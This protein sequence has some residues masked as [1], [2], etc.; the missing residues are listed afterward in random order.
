VKVALEDVTGATITTATNPVTIALAANS[1]GATLS[2]TLTATPMGGVA[3]FSNL[4][5]DKASG[6]AGY[7]LTASA[8]GFTSATSNS[9]IVMPGG[10]T[11]FAVTAPVSVAGGTQFSNLSVTAFDAF[12]NVA[13]GY[14]GTVHFTSTDGQA[15]LPADSTLNQGTGTFTATLST[16]PTQTITAT[17]KSNPAITGTSNLITVNAPA[18]G[19]PT[20]TAVTSLGQNGLIGAGLTLTVQVREVT[21]NAFTT[22]PGGT[23]SFTDTSV[24]ANS[25]SFSTCNL[26][27]GNNVVG[28]SSCNVTMTLTAPAGAHTVNATYTPNDNDHAGSSTTSSLVVNANSLF[29]VSV[30]NNGQPSPGVVDFPSLSFTGRYVTFST[31]FGTSGELYVRDTCIGADTSCASQT[32]RTVLASVDNTGLAVPPDS[33][34]AMI[35]GDGSLVAFNPICFTGSTCSYLSDSIFL[36]QVCW[37]VTT[38][39]PATS[40]TVQSKDPQNN[41]VSGLGVLSRDGRYILFRTA[42]G[43]GGTLYLRDTC[44]GAPAGSPCPAD[45]VANIDDNGVQTLDATP[46]AVSPGGRYV[47]FAAAQQFFI[48]DLQAKTSTVVNKDTAG[49][50]ITSGLTSPSMSDDGRYVTFSVSP[51]TGAEEVYA[52]D[53]CTGVSNCTP[54]TNLVSVNANAVPG[55][56]AGGAYTISTFAMDAT[57][58]YIAFASSS[59][60]L[61]PRITQSGANDYVYVRDTC[62]RFGTNPGAVVGCGES[63]LL[64]S[65]DP[66]GNPLG[67]PLFS[68]AWAMSGDGHYVVFLFSDTIDPPAGS[69]YGIQLAIVSTGH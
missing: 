68:Q 10:A 5:I 49:N 11:R 34:Q 4:S 30:G 44:I 32:T 54:T 17:D 1:T 26:A 7:I 60:D 59:N 40:S 13:T 23:I 35:S 65:L 51:T 33:V 45:T 16:V 31:N 21:F 15:L 67:F 39:C 61:D 27:Q 57:G 12:N 20:S 52:R 47:L 55:P 9:F 19:V 22:S 37:T 48:R 58:R 28:V 64:V 36:T 6:T 50:V 62:L 46:Y 2:G 53:A 56:A 8:V 24:P 43:G 18:G 3:T 25:D 66:Q 63:T 14:P 41:P 38:A 69:N 29:A 42:S